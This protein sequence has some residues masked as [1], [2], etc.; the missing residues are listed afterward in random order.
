MGAK[1]KITTAAAETIT[2]RA[3]ESDVT[4]ID[5]HGDCVIVLP[6]ACRETRGNIVRAFTTTAAGSVGLSLSPSADDMI[7]AKG[8]TGVDN[9]DL[10]NT[11]A[12]NAVGDTATIVCDGE[13]GWHAVNLLGT[14]AIES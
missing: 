10:I 2:I 5:N 8:L 3:S 12:T 6:R 9:K 4:V 11:A 13:T 1:V 14:W 7:K